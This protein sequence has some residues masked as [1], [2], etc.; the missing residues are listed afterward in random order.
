MEMVGLVCLVY[1]PYTITFSDVVYIEQSVTWKME[2]YMSYLC[3][4]FVFE[5]P[6]NLQAG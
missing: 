4:Y 2:P 5:C 3:N 1:G 6:V